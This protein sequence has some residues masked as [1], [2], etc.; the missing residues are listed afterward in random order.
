MRSAGLLEIAAIDLCFYQQIY[1]KQGGRSIIDEYS[2]RVEVNA[3]H[4]FEYY[5][6]HTSVKNY[7]FVRNVV[8]TIRG[9]DRNLAVYTW[10][11]I[12]I[13]SQLPSCIYFLSKRLMDIIFWR[14]ECDDFSSFS[15]MSSM[16]KISSSSC[17]AS[18]MK[19]AIRISHQ[20]SLT[21]THFKSLN[22]WRTFS[23]DRFT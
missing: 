3:T 16:S 17:G 1:K 6:E 11:P 19:F 4:T 23:G 14:C 7:Y 13:L 20:V 18:V 2:S 10:T 12:V 21:L 9:L 8:P 22:N 15:I 5:A